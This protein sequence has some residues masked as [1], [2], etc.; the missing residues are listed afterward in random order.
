MM[1]YE[2]LTGRNVMNFTKSSRPNPENQDQNRV[3]VTESA[4]HNN[5]TKP[6]LTSS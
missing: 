5:P 6:A 1:S 4:K 3:K 2:A